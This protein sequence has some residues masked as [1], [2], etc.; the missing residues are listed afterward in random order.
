MSIF[1]YNNLCVNMQKGLKW[2]EANTVKGKNM[3]WQ[4]KKK[5]KKKKCWTWDR[6]DWMA[7]VSVEV[8]RA[9][10]FD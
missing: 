8:M 3:E 1:Q 5:K 9:M 7:A 2:K 10:H 6:N 4:R